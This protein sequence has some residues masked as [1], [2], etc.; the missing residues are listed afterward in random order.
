MLLQAHAPDF[1]IDVLAVLANVSNPRVRY[2]DLL[3][4]FSL[5]EFV[6]RNLEPPADDDIVLQVIMLIGTFCTDPKASAQLGNPRIVNLL[7]GVLVKAAHESFD[8]DLVLQTL[9]SLYRLLHHPSSR[10]AVCANTS[11][12]DTIVSCIGWPNKTVRH[13]AN[14]SL[15]CY[16]YVPSSILFFISSNS[17]PLQS[18]IY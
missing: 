8:T 15:V 11:L 13:Y 17:L 18:V 9:F 2:S 1:R 7:N 16:P 6:T 10:V 3:A 12:A 5:V 4:R 14:S